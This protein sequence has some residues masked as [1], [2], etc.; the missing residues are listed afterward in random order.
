M[1]KIKAFLLEH[2][3]TIAEIARATG[4]TRPYMSGKVNGKL[5]KW[6]YA[7]VLYISKRSNTPLEAFEEILNLTV[8]G[9]AE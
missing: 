9:K 6:G 2:E 4:I 1:T 7:E 3:I 8:E 5:G